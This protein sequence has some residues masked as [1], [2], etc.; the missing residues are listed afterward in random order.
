M[1]LPRARSEDWRD[2]MAS[3]SLVLRRAVGDRQPEEIGAGCCRN[4]IEQR[5]RPLSIGPRLVPAGSGILH[6]VASN[7]RT[8]VFCL[9]LVKII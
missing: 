9:Y 5:S 2:V 1:G 3:R 6:S 8:V 4:P 7:Q